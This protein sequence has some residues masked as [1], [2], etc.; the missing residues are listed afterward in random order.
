MVDSFVGWVWHKLV[1]ARGAI[2]A[3]SLVAILDSFFGWDRWEFLR[4]VSAMLDQWRRPIDYAFAWTL[5]FFPFVPTPSDLTKAIFVIA[6]CIIPLPLS[7]LLQ[8]EKALMARLRRKNRSVQKRLSKLQASSRGMENDEKRRAELENS[9]LITEEEIEEVTTSARSETISSIPFNM[10]VMIPLL[11]C[12]NVM[13]IGLA[14]WGLP[15]AE[16]KFDLNQAG[17]REWIQF[18]ILPAIIIVG[19]LFYGIMLAFLVEPGSLASNYLTSFG[20]VLSAF[21]GLI[22]LLFMPVV[23]SFLENALLGASG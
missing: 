23:R 4:L 3:I 19:L 22:L 7:D 9:L 20:F 21:S 1:W 11:Y 12:F 16:S 10:R 14:G 15:A 17:F 5:Q 8:P 2:S 13:M 18:V 6:M